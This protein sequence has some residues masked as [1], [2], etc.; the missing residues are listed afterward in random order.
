MRPELTQCSYVSD[1]TPDI[2]LALA[3]T[4]PY[5]QVPALLDTMYKHISLLSSIRVHVPVS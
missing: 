1:L 4:A 3:V 2:I 5:L